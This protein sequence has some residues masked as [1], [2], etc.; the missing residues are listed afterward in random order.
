MY[1]EGMNVMAEEGMEVY[2][3]RGDGI[4]YY[5]FVMFVCVVGGI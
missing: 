3:D 5:G 1:H 2:I 4:Y